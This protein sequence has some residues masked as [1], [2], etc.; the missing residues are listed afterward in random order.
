[1]L[2]LCRETHGIIKVIMIHPLAI[3]DPCTHF[4]CNPSKSW[5]H[6]SLKHQ[7]STPW[8]KV[9]E[10]YSQKYQQIKHKVT[11]Q[12]LIHFGNT[13][14]NQISLRTPNVGPN[15]SWADMQV[16]WTG[17]SRFQNK[18]E[19]VC[20]FWSACLSAWCMLGEGLV[21]HQPEQQ[22]EIS[23]GWMNVNVFQLHRLWPKPG[24]DGW[25]M[26]G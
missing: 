13:G 24:Y 7:I 25:I 8:V 20:P 21:L 2:W 26:D 12:P 4:H 18:Y 10:S 22:V 5:Q 17:K 11:R 1:M 9:R 14:M 3:N 19:Y 23:D 16:Q 6:I 15:F